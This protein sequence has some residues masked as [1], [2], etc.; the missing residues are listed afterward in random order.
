MI[1]FDELKFSQEEYI[2]NLL[3][4]VNE[5]LIDGSLTHESVS[6]LSQDNLFSIWGIQ[7]QNVKHIDFSH[8]T[9][10]DF[11][12]I[13]F[14]SSTLFSDKMPKFF[15]KD[16]ILAFK[17]FNL[18]EDDED[19]CLAII[20]N[21]TQF[22][23]HDFFKN[24]NIELVDYS[25]KSN[26]THFHMEGVLCNIFRY[27]NNPKIIAY[28]KSWKKRGESVLKALKD[29][30][31]RIKN[32]QP[33]HAISISNPL[34]DNNTKPETQ[35]QIENMVEKLKQVDCEVIDVH[36]FFR[37]LNC[38]A[39]DK[40]MFAQ[41]Q[42]TSYKYTFNTPNKI[43]I[44]ISRV[45]TEFGSKNGF[46]ISGGGQSWAIPIVAYF[47]AYCK[48]KNNELTLE[49]FAELCDKCS[50]KTKNCEKIIDFKKLIFQG[51]TRSCNWK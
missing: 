47:Y 27:A 17:Y 38:S 40:P 23:L 32:G 20:D 28:T 39:A 34:I 37:E 6:N 11:D 49:N 8:L 48:S 51:S 15:D 7:Y 2:K 9:K 22:Y 41:E 35:N 29:I 45:I 18:I 5:N 33:I 30:Y 46:A 10:E 13:P 25:A 19:V 12:K 50:K 4:K 43:G 31:K 36:K 1:L 24:K 21:P 26:E 44:P 3:S 14:S 16:K 42:L